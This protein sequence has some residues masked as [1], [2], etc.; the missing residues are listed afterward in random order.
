[1]LDRNKGRRYGPGEDECYGYDGGTFS[2]LSR[3]ANEDRLY[4]TGNIEN[5]KDDGLFNVNRLQVH[6]DD[7]L[8]LKMCKDCI[9]KLTNL[10]FYSMQIEKSQDILRKLWQKL[11]GPV[12]EEVVEC[13]KQIC[14]ESEIIDEACTST[15]T[16]YE[17]T[18]THVCFD[19]CGS[20]PVTASGIEN[21]NVVAEIENVAANKENNQCNMDKNESQYENLNSN[22]ENEDAMES[23]SEKVE[24]TCY[25]E[26]I[27]EDVYVIEESIILD[28]A[29]ECN[30]NLEEMQTKNDVIPRCEKVTNKNVSIAEV[31]PE[32]I[33]K[34][35]FKHK[36]SRVSKPLLEEKKCG[37]C[38]KVNQKSNFKQI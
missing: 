19:E 13:I 9:G 20:L 18:T 37:I 26:E 30:S 16:K 17:Q 27:E 2:I 5:I 25:M 33:S 29:T 24:S 34:R 28:N 7:E 10:Y 11:R 22:T 1:M 3:N 8:P 4:H 38:E 21:P 31:R 23:V 32:I 15:S 36:Q 6:K 12:S 35:S 14:D